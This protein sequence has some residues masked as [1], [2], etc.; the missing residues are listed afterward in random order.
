MRTERK[1]S[2]ISL[3]KVAIKVIMKKKRGTM[4]ALCKDQKD[5]KNC[6]TV[7]ERKDI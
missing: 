7:V 3:A 5:M 2:A 4:P 1:D 6:A